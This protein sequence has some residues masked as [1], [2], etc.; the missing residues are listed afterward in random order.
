MRAAQQDL[1][2][3]RPSVTIKRVARQPLSNSYAAEWTQC[4]MCA[5]GQQALPERKAEPPTIKIYMC[6]QATIASMQHHVC[7]GATGIA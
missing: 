4:P 2:N 1:E 6:D 7:C 5:A 3:E